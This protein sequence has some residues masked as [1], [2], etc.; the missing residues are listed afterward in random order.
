MSAD[1]MMKIEKINKY[2]YPNMRPTAEPKLFPKMNKLFYI[3][4]KQ[5]VIWH[6]QA[7]ISNPIVIFK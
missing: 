1:K 5:H 3:L 2:E 6:A 4:N 7:H